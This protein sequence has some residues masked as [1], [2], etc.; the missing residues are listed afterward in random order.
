M[1]NITILLITILSLFSCGK[2]DTINHYL[3]KP[4]T[5]QELAENGFYKYSYTYIIDDED[6]VDDTIKSIVNN[7][8]EIDKFY[9]QAEDHKMLMT[10]RHKYL[11][12]SAS[13]DGIGM[14]PRMTKPTGVGSNSYREIIWER[15]KING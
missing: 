5:Q 6:K 8:T 10:L 14:E 4:L 3:T 7:E 1:K 13:M 12:C 15:F 11:H 9:S 2:R